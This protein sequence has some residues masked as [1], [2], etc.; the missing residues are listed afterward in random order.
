MEE[1]TNQRKLNGAGKLAPPNRMMEQPKNGRA[2]RK[3]GGSGRRHTTPVSRINGSRRRLPRYLR[4]YVRPCLM[5]M[6][7]VFQLQLVLLYLDLTANFEQHDVET[8]YDH[9]HRRR[10]H[11]RRRSNDGGSRSGAGLETSRDDKSNGAGYYS[12]KSSKSVYAGYYSSKSSKSVDGKGKGGAGGYYNSKS[13]KSGKS[14]DGKG[15]GADVEDDDSSMDTGKGKGYESKKSKSTYGKGKGGYDSKKSKSD[16]KS[17]YGKG[18]KGKVRYTMD[19]L[20]VGYV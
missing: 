4:R 13:S 17:G 3:R 19:I 6:F 16:K 9:P 5:V 15:K 12:S 14:S 2:N 8:L 7:V 1:S 18:S 20:L 11:R 10:P